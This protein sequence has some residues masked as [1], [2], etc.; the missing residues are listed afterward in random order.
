MTRRDGTDHSVTSAGARVVL[1]ATATL[2]LAGCNAGGDPA[3]VPTP[4]SPRASHT[5]PGAAAPATA[6]PA[7]VSTTAPTAAPTPAPPADPCHTSGVTYC[8]LNPAVTQA[9]IGQTICVRGWTA[10]VR[11]PESYTE[12]L[13]REQ[14]AQEGLP[15]GLSSYEEDHLLSGGGVADDD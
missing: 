15:G 6:P 13:K 1:L 4:P 12:A 11:P 10:T 2:A 14:I 5:V 8:A 7:S 3:A 9:S